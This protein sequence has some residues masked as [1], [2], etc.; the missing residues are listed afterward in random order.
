VQSLIE[1]E[2]IDE[3][4]ISATDEQIAAEDN[5]NLVVENATDALP[6]D[7]PW[8]SPQPLR[9]LSGKL[10]IGRT[11]IDRHHIVINNSLP[12]SANHA[13]DLTSCL[14]VYVNEDHSRF[15][16]AISASSSSTTRRV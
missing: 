4:A 16:A 8:L 5:L 1:A 7:R 15:N 3:W 10:L 12:R 2:D 6:H 9:V 11:R 14:Q 13:G